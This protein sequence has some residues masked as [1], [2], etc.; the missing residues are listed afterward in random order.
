MLASLA[1][2]YSALASPV[3]IARCE[4]T[5]PTVR[6]M[7]TDSSLL[8]MFESG[9]P[10]AEFLE[11]TKA[12]RE[13]WFE[14]NSVAQVDASLVARARVVGGKWKVLVVAIDACNDSMNSLPY[15]ARLADSVPG[16]ELRVIL[17]EKGKPLQ[18][19]HR[20]LDGRAATPTFLLIDE[21]GKE[22]G[23]IVE[24]P[25]EL[26]HWTHALRTSGKADELSDGKR[27][28]YERDRGRGITTEMVELLEAARDGAPI[29]D[30]GN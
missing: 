24:L 16:M 5:L 4:A 28:F 21:A 3:H 26:R 22:A 8:A 12:R 14:K 30:R 27:D 9:Q 15:I 13:G 25:R 2:M 20:T 23:C 7:P 6:H 18:E 10:Y 17:P 19:S 29:C 1:L 11:G